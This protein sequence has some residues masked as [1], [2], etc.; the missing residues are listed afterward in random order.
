MTP[1]ER[2]PTVR[3]TE[4]RKLD[5]LFCPKFHPERK[6]TIAASGWFCEAE[7]TWQGL[8]ERAQV[9]LG[10]SREGAEAVAREFAW[11]AVVSAFH[12]TPV[13]NPTP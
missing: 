6:G 13:G 12:A 2:W 1:E 3:I 8:T 7:A 4:S 10:L 5:F 11:C 9:H